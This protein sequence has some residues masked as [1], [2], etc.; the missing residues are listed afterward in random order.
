MQVNRIDDYITTINLINKNQQFT[1]TNFK[2]KKIPTKVVT[3]EKVLDAM[4]LMSVPLTAV[5]IN[6]NAQN[7]TENSNKISNAELK[8]LRTE[9][10]EKMDAY[11]LDYN[12]LPRIDKNNCLLISKLLDN[13]VFKA[14][15]QKS[16]DILYYT[17][18]KT[19]EEQLAK[20]KLLETVG[21]D[22][23]LIDSRDIDHFINSWIKTEEDTENI[24]KLYNYTVNNKDFYNYLITNKDSSHY[25]DYRYGFSE[26]CEDLK[27]NPELLPK[28]IE[29]E[30]LKDHAKLLFDT[31]YAGDKNYEMVLDTLS[32]KKELLSNKNVLKQIEEYYAAID[33]IDALSFN[34]ILNIEDE[35]VI[36]NILETCYTIGK[37][38]MDIPKD[39]KYHMVFDTL[40]NTKELYKNK[41]ISENLYAILS[42]KPK[43]PKITELVVSIIKKIDSSEELSQN[44]ELMNN[45]GKILASIKTRVKGEQVLYNLNNICPTNSEP[46]QLPN[47][48]TV[49]NCIKKYGVSMEKIENL[50]NVSPS[51]YKARIE[52]ICKELGISES[53]LDYLI[54]KYNIA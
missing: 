43:A 50:K 27:D 46:E 18:C 53:T 22:S 11:G 3:Q 37:G 20:V 1:N 42:T 36:N 17:D 34:K 23:E 29:D 5:V 44:Q 54:K 47:K 32:T 21:K 10:A 30:N 16:K 7:K 48:E 26:L 4:A 49:E 52:K 39:R 9:I 13:H 14:D 2:A 40:M 31:Y 28:V 41:N 35:N 6:A 24:I 45:I 33:P 12:Y 19:Y 51:R 25:H 8:K 38:H 15:V